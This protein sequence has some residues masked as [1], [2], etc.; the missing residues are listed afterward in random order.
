LLGHASGAKH[1]RRVSLK[2]PASECIMLVLRCLHYLYCYAYLL[3]YEAGTKDSRM[4]RLH[5]YCR[6]S[7]VV[8]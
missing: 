2:L 7:F 8:P 1:K 4:A 3:S 5:L 6:S